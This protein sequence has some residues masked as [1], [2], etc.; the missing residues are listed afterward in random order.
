[1]I[2]NSVRSTPECSDFGFLS[3][4][5]ALG[6]VVFSEGLLITLHWDAQCLGRAGQN[7]FSFVELLHLG[8][9]LF[10]GTGFDGVFALDGVAP[11]G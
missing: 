4:V 3:A 11:G 1:M 6:R 7:D 9:G 8:N 2:V 10:L 5:E